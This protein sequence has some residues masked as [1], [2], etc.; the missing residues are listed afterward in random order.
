MRR[1]QQTDLL[2]V[3]EDVADRG[4][5]DRQAR[6]PG[7]GLR[8]DR[9]AIADMAR[10]QGPQQVARARIQGIVRG[11]RRAGHAWGYKAAAAGAQAEAPTGDRSEE[12]TSE[13]QSLMRI[14][15]AVFCL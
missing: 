9:L 4:R 1:G 3:G 13:L 7:Q 15:Y 8:T 11:R 5:A 12:H 10:D 6:V 14:S 2:E